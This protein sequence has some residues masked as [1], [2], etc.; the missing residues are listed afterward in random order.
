MEF[1]K[2][3]DSKDNHPDSH[4]RL[5]NINDLT[6]MGLNITRFSPIPTVGDAVPQTPVRSGTN[7]PVPTST[8]RPSGESRLHNSDPTSTKEHIQRGNLYSSF[9][10]IVGHVQ[11][12]KQTKLGSNDELS[13]SDNSTLTGNTTLFYPGEVPFR[14]QGTSTSPLERVKS[15]NIQ[16]KKLRGTSGTQTR[17]QDAIGNTISLP[18]QP[19]TGKGG[20][21]KSSQNN[22]SR[23]QPQPSTSNSGTN[24]ASV[25]SPRNIGTDMPHV[26]CS[27]C[28]GDDHFRK[29]SLQDNFCNR[30]RSRSHATHICRALT[31]S[32]KSNNIC[33]YCGSIYH[34]SGNCTNWP[35]D[36][37]EEPRATPWDL[38]RY[39]P[40][41]RA[42]TKNS[43]VP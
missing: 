15:Q 14:N 28:G 22:Q 33:V 7:I 24:T 6:N 21:K 43:G 41:C 16:V 42:N 26:Q 10:G 1:I 30:C 35:N 12:Q 39:G 34:T 5:C 11:T 36:S 8:P 23:T 25:F 20:M 3:R 27:A 19:T 17:S 37:R 9:T 40:H 29:G 38:H 32:G 18:S 4:S 2:E 31:N 13:G